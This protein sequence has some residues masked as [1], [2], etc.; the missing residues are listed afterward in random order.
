MRIAAPRRSHPPS[1]VL[2]VV[3]VPFR[4][5]HSS[6]FPRYAIIT[7]L[8]GICVLTFVERHNDGA[9]HAFVADPEV[10]LEFIEIVGTVAEIF[11]EVLIPFSLYQSVDALRVESS[12]R[13][14]K[15]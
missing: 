14:P 11:E 15:E 6:W 7:Y 5:F 10:C 12:I 8:D 13:D 1:G 3:L 2:F 9:F 4:N